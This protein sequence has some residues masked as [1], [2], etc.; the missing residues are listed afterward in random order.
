MELKANFI[1]SAYFYLS[2]ANALTLDQSK[3]SFIKS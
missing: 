3:T 1:V 2:S